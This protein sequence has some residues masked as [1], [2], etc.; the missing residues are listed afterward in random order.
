MFTNELG[1]GADVMMRDGRVMTISD[2]RKGNIRAVF[3]SFPYPEHGS[4][5]AFNMM[6]YKNNKGAE[7]QWLLIEH[8][9]AQLKHRQQCRA[10]G[11]G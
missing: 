11:L 3:A 9:P 2:N 4:A 1:K 8:T 5:Y 6:K 7:T 10:L